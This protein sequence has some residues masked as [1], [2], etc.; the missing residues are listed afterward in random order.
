MV[1]DRLRVAAA[2]FKILCSLGTKPENTHPQRDTLVMRTW[3]NIR[4]TDDLTRKRDIYE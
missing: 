2:K 1:P 3:N 4:Y